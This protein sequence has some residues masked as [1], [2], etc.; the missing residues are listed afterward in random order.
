MHHE[1]IRL[2][3]AILKFIASSQYWVSSEVESSLGPLSLKDIL[4]ADM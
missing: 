4:A 2:L 3:L 1:I